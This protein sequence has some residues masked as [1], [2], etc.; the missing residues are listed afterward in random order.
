MISNPLFSVVINNYNY[1]HY[2]RESI[3]SALAQAY[4]PL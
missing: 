2:L 1:A 3:D 4:L